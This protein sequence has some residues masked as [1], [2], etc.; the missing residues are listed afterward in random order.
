MYSKISTQALSVPMMPAASFL[1]NALASTCKRACRKPFWRMALWMALICCSPVA[2]SFAQRPSDTGTPVGSRSF[3][4]PVSFAQSASNSSISSTSDPETAVSIDMAPTLPVKQIELIVEL[5]PEDSGATLNLTLDPSQ[6]WKGMTEVE[7]VEK[8][9]KIHFFIT[10][11]REMTLTQGQ[12]ASVTGWINTGEANR[13]IEKMDGIVI[14]VNIDMRSI[15][16]IDPS[17]LSAEP[18]IVWILDYEGNRVGECDLSQ[19]NALVDAIAALPKG[20]YC[21]VDPR[22][23]GLM[24]YKVRK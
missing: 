14:T 4:V 9:G 8:E 23:N 16:N 17:E 1:A 7:K 11:E 2:Q 12:F 3:S 5:A 10:P 19:A 18:Y 6:E 21:F 13:M 20:L 22:P 24:P 15:S